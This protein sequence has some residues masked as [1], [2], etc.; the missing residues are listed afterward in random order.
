MEWNNILSAIFGALIA[1]GAIFFLYQLYNIVV[2]DAK[3]R[4]IKHPRFWGFLTFGKNTGGG[5]LLYL[6]RRRNCPI[7]NITEKEKLEISK[8]KKATGIGLS[9]V[10]IGTIGIIISQMML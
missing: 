3:T 7:I 10:C 9:F 2:I 6:I 4:G 1:V 8:R 5:L